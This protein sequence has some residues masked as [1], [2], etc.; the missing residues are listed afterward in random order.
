MSVYRATYNGRII[1]CVPHTGDTYTATK[2]DDKKII[3][4]TIPMILNRLGGQ[5]IDIS[6]LWE[7]DLHSRLTPG[8]YNPEVTISNHPTDSSI[9]RKVFAFYTAIFWHE[10]AFSF[11]V[12][13]RH[14]VNGVHDTETYDDK[15]VSET[16][17]NDAGRFDY[18]FQ[19]EQDGASITDLQNNQIPIMDQE[20]VFN[21][22]L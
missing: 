4:D 10:Q 22:Y 9:E 12:I 18:F 15:Y 6:Y 20:G 5:G 8:T 11:N 17:N 21:T 16:V 1:D 2:V 14:F 7:N 13:V 3:I 19:L